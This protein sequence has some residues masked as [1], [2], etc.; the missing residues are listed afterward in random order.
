MKKR[1]QKLHN[2]NGEVMLESLLV[3]MVTIFLLFMILALTCVWFQRLTVTTVANDTAARIAAGFRY[4]NEDLY[5]TSYD[6]DDLADMKT[7]RYWFAYKGLKETAA[8]AAEDFAVKRLMKSSFAAK[9][10]SETDVDFELVND[11]I[12]RNHV[13]VTITGEYDLPFIDMLEFLGLPKYNAYTVEG[14]A[15]CTD[16]LSYINDIKFACTVANTVKD[17]L[18]SFA[19]VG[20]SAIKLVNKVIGTIKEFVDEAKEAEAS[21]GTGDGGGFSAGGTAGAGGGGGGGGSR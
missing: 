7:Y 11:G 9:K 2:E 5:D 20:D 21:S 18:G 16:I 1:I 12:G 10:T 19:K 6:E 8:E 14:Y 4:G 3:Y 17:D 13:V 15:D